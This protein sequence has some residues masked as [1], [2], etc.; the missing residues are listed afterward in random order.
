[1]AE[2]QQTI[3]RLQAQVDEQ[4][5]GGKL[6][7]ADTDDNENTD[8]NYQ[9]PFTK[10]RSADEED[11]GMRKYLKNEAKVADLKKEIRADFRKLRR[12]ESDKIFKSK[13]PGRIIAR[14]LSRELQAERSWT[15][16][17]KY[18]RAVPSV[19]VRFAR[20]LAI[21][22]GVADDENLAFRFQRRLNTSKWE[23]GIKE[24]KQVRKQIVF[25]N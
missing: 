9:P 2:M 21:E 22:Q 3:A 5:D 15:V 11:T 12:K 4:K 24:A 1:M 14:L 7:R 13:L 6:K 8:G 25:I 18:K 23:K 10:L 20:R 16:G 19:V 17:N